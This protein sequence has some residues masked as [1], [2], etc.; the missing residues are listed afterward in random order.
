LL[1]SVVVFN[2]GGILKRWILSINFSFIKK[3][4]YFGN[5]W[6]CNVFTFTGSD[7]KQWL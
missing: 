4:K 3:K 7:L 2:E 5:L 6:L 1:P